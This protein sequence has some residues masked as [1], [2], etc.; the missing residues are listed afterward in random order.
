MDLCYVG[1]LLGMGGVHVEAQL[2]IGGAYVEALLDMGGA[3]GPPSPLRSYNNQ[4][5]HR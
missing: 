4:A 3:L 5:C 2:D 1:A